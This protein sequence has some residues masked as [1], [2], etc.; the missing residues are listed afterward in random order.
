L[1]AHD[2]LGMVMCLCQCLAQS[3]IIFQIT[4]FTQRLQLLVPLVDG[5][6]AVAVLGRFVVNNNF[7]AVRPVRWAGAQAVELCRCELPL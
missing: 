5:F 2:S 1:P 3:L 6:R 4:K 7:S